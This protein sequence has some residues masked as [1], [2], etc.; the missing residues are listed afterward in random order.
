M[1]HDLPLAKTAKDAPEM[2][3]RAL[4]WRDFGLSERAR[5][6]ELVE[7]ASQPNPFFEEWHLFPSLE[8]LDPTCDVTLWWLEDSDG[9]A[10]GL[11]P[12]Q[13]QS[14]YYGRPLPHWRNWMHANC[15]LG[16]PLVR[17]GHEMRFWTEFFAWLDG[18]A[19]L[20]MFFHLAGLPLDT[21][22]ADA[23]DACLGET[24]RRGRC[25]H[26]EERAMLRSAAAPQD[27]LAEVLSTK[28]RKELRRQRRRLEELGAVETRFLQDDREL[29]SWIDAFLRLEAAGWKGEQGTAT[30]N[31]IAKT[32]ILTRA[33]HGAAACGKLERRDLRLDGEPIAMLATFRTPPGA[34]SY[35][36][37]FHEDYA[38]F[39]PGVLLQIENLDSLADSAID[40][41]DSCAC[42]DH[43]MI[44]RIWRERR[45]IARYSI[46][47][48]GAARQTLF[49]ALLAAEGRAK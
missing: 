7:H 28:R 4:A 19:A 36:T 18:A 30:A 20:P 15:F 34:S 25:V 23:L 33:L 35:K 9:T 40:W 41:V 39:S 2:R 12:L 6:S 3:V 43:P 37:A 44:D 8:A 14:D 22:L 27:Y 5:L 1:Q 17:Q 42:E 29:Q 31:D 38:R 16:A 11:L 32:E 48:G 49:G 21:A 45:R 47:I 10:V 13:R 26:I 24:G 46:G